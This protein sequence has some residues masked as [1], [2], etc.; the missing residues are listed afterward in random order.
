[1]MSKIRTAGQDENLETIIRQHRRWT[2][3]VEGSRPI[4]AGSLIL[5]NRRLLFLHR[6]ESSPDVS[7][8][9]KKLADAPIEMVLDHALTLHKSS[10]QIPLSSIMQVGIFT[11]FGFPFPRFCL[12]VLYLAGKKL[13]PYTAAFQFGKSPSD[14][15][16][17]PQVIVDWSWKRAIRRAIHEAGR[18]KTH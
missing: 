9:I 12:S 4:G 16:P 3:L 14:M 10:F 2:R 5:T 18:L 7:A 6:I 15:F 13:A 8:S 11:L 17:K 1:L